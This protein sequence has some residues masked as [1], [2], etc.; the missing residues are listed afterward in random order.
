MEQFADEA[1][2]TPVGSTARTVT[3]I[4]WPEEVAEESTERGSKRKHTRRLAVPRT[5]EAANG[6][7]YLANP[8]I[9]DV[10]TIDSL[11]YRVDAI[12]SQTE[13]ETFLHVL[14]VGVHEENRSG[15]RR[16]N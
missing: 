15:L 8:A 11:E 3:A 16:R 10:W 12:E 6:G 13:A 7:S 14:R 2:C 5:S 1:S 9:G 4:V